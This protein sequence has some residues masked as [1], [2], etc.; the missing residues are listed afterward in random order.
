[1]TPIYF[2]QDGK[3]FYLYNS[4]HAAECGDSHET[5]SAPFAVK[6]ND[7][8]AAEKAREWFITDYCRKNDLLPH[9]VFNG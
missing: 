9:S 3:D 6:D 4:I 2:E 7:T 5:V 8:Q 1:M